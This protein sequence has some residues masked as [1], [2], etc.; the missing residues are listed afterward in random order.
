[1]FTTRN[2]HARMGGVIPPADRARGQGAALAISR[3]CL[4]TLKNSLF[5]SLMMLRYLIRYVLGL[6]CALLFLAMW[7][8]LLLSWWNHW[9]FSMLETAGVMFLGSLAFRA[10]IWYYD[11]LILKFVPR[12]YQLYLWN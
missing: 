7:V 6:A 11:L 9:N 4:R 8:F 2:S 5:F 12:G 3:F 10:L 1:M